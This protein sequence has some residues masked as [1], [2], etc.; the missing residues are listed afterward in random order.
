[1]SINFSLSSFNESLTIAQA[2]TVASVASDTFTHTAA[3]PAVI[4]EVSTQVMRD[5]FQYSTDADDL[6]NGENYDIRYYQDMTKWPDTYVL[7][8]AHGACNHAAVGGNTVNT[9]YLT[10][11]AGV[12]YADNRS[13]MKHDFIRFLSNEIFGTPFGAD[14]FNN[15]VTLRNDIEK[16]G[17]ELYTNKIA[18]Q[19]GYLSTTSTQ[20]GMIAENITDSVGATITANYCTKESLDSQTYTA[21]ST[22]S[23]N[24]SDGTAQ[25]ITVGATHGTTTSD[26][27]ISVSHNIME[28]MLSTAD[29]RA[30]FLDITSGGTALYAPNTADVTGTTR[31]GENVIG[32]TYYN[33]NPLPFRE[34]DTLSF[35]VPVTSASQAITANASTSSRTYTVTLVLKDSPSNTVV[36]DGN[37]SGPGVVGT[38]STSG[39]TGGSAIV[40]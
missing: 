19:L 14:L 32:D 38:I 35:S 23:V 15:E 4:Y 21:A 39:T 20:T 12:A 34:G 26:S 8:V 7:N 5:V 11:N 40:I 25:T 31:S 2:A 27:V 10:D 16:I 3:N 17:N 22:V 30:R 37:I 9:A 36:N 24:S 28:Q 18:F 1:M 13:L 33:R 6:T 29:G